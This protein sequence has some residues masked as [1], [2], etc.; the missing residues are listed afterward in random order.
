MMQIETNKNH[1]IPVAEIHFSPFSILDD[2]G[3]VFHWQGRIF[4]A[5]R[6]DYVDEV[7]TM[8]ASGLIDGL[9]KD[10]LFPASQITSYTLDDY[11]LVIEH[12]LAPVITYPHEWSFE[13]LKQAAQVALRVNEIASSY[14]YQTKDIHPYNIIFFGLKPKFIDLGSFIKISQNQTSYLYAFNEYIK[15]Y[16]VPLYIWHLGDAH[17]ARRFMQRW[18]LMTPINSYISYRLGGS[19][20]FFRKAI[21]K[22][23]INYYKMQQIPFL[24]EAERPNPK[25]LKFSSLFKFIK[26]IGFPLR[27]SKI[28]SLQSK[29]N[30]LKLPKYISEWGDYHGKLYFQDSRPALSE[31]LIR[32]KDLIERL[33]SEKIT[34]IAGNQGVLC[35]SIAEMHHVRQIVCLDYDEKAINAGF[36]RLR[37]SQNTPNKINFAVTN[38]FYPEKNRFESPPETRFKADLVLAL[39]LTH[40]LILTQGYSLDYIL[41]TI[42]NYSNQYVAIEFMPLGLFDSITKE[43]LPPPHWY[44]EEWFKKEFSQKFEIIEIL[45]LE[46]N[47][48]LYVGK[49][50]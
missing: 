36:N 27:V 26:F 35:Q 49:L 34:D 17:T 10:E 18:K 14:G 50:K 9:V 23:W 7:K 32:I 42:S 15:C 37:E 11:A 12:E 13:M 3:R 40:H 30:N 22:I 46:S 29:T 41:S 16:F 31:R 2:F 24:L 43:G 48:T 19:Y 4:R 21:S 33:E 6:E 38:P 8:F 39:A 45:R 5:I 28:S 20:G 1:V 47:R 44:N 25:L